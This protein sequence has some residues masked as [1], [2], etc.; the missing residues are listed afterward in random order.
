MPL[1]VGKDVRGGAF[2]SQMT[3][4][5]SPLSKC[6][7]AG[8][9]LAL[10]ISLP[11][12][13]G[14]AAPAVR[15]PRYE[16]TDLGPLP[17]VYSIYPMQI[18]EQGEIVGILTMEAPFISGRH[19]FIWRQGRFTDLQPLFPDYLQAMTDFEAP[20]TQPLDLNDAG[21]IIVLAGI[22]EWH[23]G[24]FRSP[25][26]FLYHAG[27][28][29]PFVEILGSRST[30]PS[31]INKAGDIVGFV[32]GPSTRFQ[33]FVR[34][35]RKPLQLLG[36]LP[37]YL[38]SR[39]HRISNSGHIIGDVVN[40]PGP[41]YVRAVVFRS[42]GIVEI[43]P[44]PGD[45]SSSAWA[46]NDRGRVIALSGSG[47]WLSPRGFLWRDGQATPLLLPNDVSS[48]LGGINNSDQVVG[49]SRDANYR[50]RGFLYSNGIIYDLNDLIE[51]GTGWFID[52]AND[53][54]DHA[55]IV[56]FGAFHGEYRGL[57]LTRAK[58]SEE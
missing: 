38:D 2:N 41:N 48:Q 49:T 54:N 46:V 13:S 57:L 4:I 53:I 15:T 47:G 55:A 10:T 51:A 1:E 23:L 12:H 34:Y 42:T 35:A 19:T 6:C 17:G 3:S 50:R 39:A 58:H 5:K 30:E 26:L 28:M 8:I 31:G 25:E 27:G 16:V 33:A 14:F 29:Q 20:Q 24:I 45:Y 44:L 52:T 32:S 18:N 21:D 36:T 22:E 11:H 40:P 7:S 37:G 9:L 56:G 43:A